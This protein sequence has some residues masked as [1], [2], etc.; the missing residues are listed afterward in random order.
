MLRVISLS[1]A[2]LSTR[3]LSPGDR[4]TAFVVCP[5]SIGGEA[6]SPNQWLYLRET[7]PRQ[8]LKAFRGVRAISQFDW[9]FT[10]TP[11]SS[12][13]FSTATGSALQLVLPSLQPAQG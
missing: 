13:T 8:L 5:G 11:S 4:L 1:A 12:K 7:A 10:P 6:L 9:P 3:R 2:D